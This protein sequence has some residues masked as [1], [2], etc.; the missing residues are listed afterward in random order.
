[1]LEIPVICGPT[2]SG[3]TS[4]AVELAGYFPLEV[5]SADSRQMIKYL[6][7]GTAKSTRAEQEKVPFHLI[8]IVEPGERYTAYRFIE[9]AEEIIEKTICQRKIPVVVGGTG[10]YLKA[11]TEGVV[12]IDNKDAS[13]REKLE[14]EMDTKGAEKM[15][16]R[17]EQIDSLEAAAIHPNN[18]VRIVRALEIFYLTG[19]TKSELVANGTYKKSKYDFQYFCLIPER[20]KLYQVIDDRVDLM[21]NCGLPGEVKSLVDKGL[22]KNIKNA[23]VIGYNEMIDYINGICSLEE[24]V[25][26]IKQNTRR[27]AKRQITWF[28]HQV[29]ARYFPNK[30]GL[31]EEL[32]AIL[33]KIDYV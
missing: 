12:K 11:L 24:A 18:K 33:S 29:S 9:D 31:T 17:L 8:D 14:S 22:E 20:Q 4:V 32:K 16:A 5:V 19:K 28:R 10:L 30:S 26:Q 3:K 25:N 13:I 21:V 15:Y 7:I 23:N 6:D 1:M 27:Y 2:G